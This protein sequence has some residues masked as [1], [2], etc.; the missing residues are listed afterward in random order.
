METIRDNIRDAIE[1]LLVD[2]VDS[3]AK[4]E[5]IDELTDT[6]C[7]KYE[8]LLAQGM[9]EDSAFD[10][11]LSGIGDVDELVAFIN[12][13]AA[14]ESQ[15]HF[16]FDAAFQGFEQIMGQVKSAINQAKEPIKD[17]FHQAKG[18][19]KDAVHQAKGPIK[20]AVNQAKGPVMD[21]VHQAKGPIKD[22]AKEF[23]ENIR[24]VGHDFNAATRSHGQYRYDRSI[25]SDGIRGIDIHTTSGDV[26]V[27]FSEDDNIYIVEWTK[28]PLE[29][30][31]QAEV[32]V[33]PDGVL[34]VS[35]GRS[36]ASSIFFGWGML[37]S[38]LEIFLPRKNWSF[39]RVNTSSGDIDFGP[40]I[41]LDSL[42]VRT[43]SGDL[44]CQAAACGALTTHTISG[45]VN[46][47]GVTGTVSAES[48]SGDILLAGTPTQVSAKMI[49]GDLNLRCGSMPQSLDAATVSG[50]LRVAIPE[51]DGFSI[52]YRKVSGSL[53]SDF[54]LMTTLNSHEGEAVYR[55]GSLRP[56]YTFSTTS[57]DIRITRV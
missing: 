29:E 47:S 18:P 49:S 37:N 12:A 53:Q 46:C 41:S 32:T 15:S 40:G 13:S 17:A 31:H 36:A 33:R 30:D 7:A 56:A 10:Q 14:Q 27:G 11:V 42:S 51:N 9:D 4:S 50:D 16:D 45:D 25:S 48:T 57:G 5:V 20:D 6:L 19:I 35:Q 8:D 55:S 34:C 28:T 52:R 21:A 23:T 1:S 26:T 3:A 22:A 44:S 38:D 54:N 39:V 43:G 24:K 2:A